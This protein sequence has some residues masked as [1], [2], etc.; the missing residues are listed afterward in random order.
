MRRPTWLRPW[1]TSM[2]CE[3]AASRMAFPL[4]VSS[5]TSTAGRW[6]ER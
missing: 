6:L 1:R 4:E 2:A 3:R 5:N